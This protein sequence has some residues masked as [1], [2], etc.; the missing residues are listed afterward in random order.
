M[1]VLQLPLQA[2]ASA[3]LEPSKSKL[4][5]SHVVVPEKRPLPR[6]LF[7]PSFQD[8]V[9]LALF[10]VFDAAFTLDTRPPRLFPTA[11]TVFA[12]HFTYHD[13][14]NHGDLE[15]ELGRMSFMLANLPER[16][17]PTV[18]TPTICQVLQAPALMA[19]WKRAIPQLKERAQEQTLWIIRHM[20]KQRPAQT[21]G[22]HKSSFITNPVDYET[23]GIASGLASQ[24]WARALSEMTT[25]LCK[26]QA[27]QDEAEAFLQIFSLLKDP[28]GGLENIP[29]KSVEC[30]ARMLSSVAAVAHQAPRTHAI[31]A[32]WPAAIAQAA[33][34]ALFLGCPLLEG[35]SHVHFTGHQQL[36]YAYVPLDKLPRSEFSISTHVATIVEEMLLN[37]SEGG[38]CIAPIAV[39]TYPTLPLEDGKRMPVIIDGN[40]RASATMV[41]RMIAHYPDILTAE[42]YKAILD[43]FCHAHELGLKWKIDLADV[44]Q[45][46][47]GSAFHKRLLQSKMS[48]VR[49]F[50]QVDTIPALVVREDN[51]HTVCQQRPP[52]A[53]RPR[54][55]LPIHQ[56]IY[57]DE[58]LGFAFPQAGQ[59]HG[60]ATGFKPMRLNQ[61]TK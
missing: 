59:V 25:R 41:L 38:C 5:G 45:V 23:D 39:S 57:N 30:F 12:Q 32:N 24:L 35:I 56:A 36:P 37:E 43:E 15:T 61:G 60:R 20:Q 48:T 22:I 6:D 46:L 19:G 29:D 50:L 27:T 44:L 28:L 16:G 42:D 9:D 49:Q 7:S 34:E 10:R 52:L 1:Q 18:F 21:E 13:W 26:S 33:Q 14:M 8:L 3:S 2:P 40:H 53:D 55:L 47:R 11:E 54:L 31:K 4:P 51:F 17:L 58:E